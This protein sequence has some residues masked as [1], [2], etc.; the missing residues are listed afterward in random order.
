MTLREGRWKVY[1]NSAIFAAFLSSHFKI[2]KSLNLYL[3]K[4]EGEKEKKKYTAKSE[5]NGITYLNSE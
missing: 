4:G 1:V 3:P 2:I 5:D